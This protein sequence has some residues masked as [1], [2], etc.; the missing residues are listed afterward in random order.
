MRVGNSGTTASSERE[1]KAS[2]RPAPKAV[3]RNSVELLPQPTSKPVLVLGREQ[4]VEMVRRVRPGIFTT[5]FSE[6]GVSVR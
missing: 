6:G 1:G 5:L 3:E 4:N 2:R